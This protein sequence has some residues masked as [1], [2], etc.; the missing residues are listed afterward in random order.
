MLLGA[1]VVLS[2]SDLPVA[3]GRGEGDAG[4]SRSE[5]IEAPTIVGVKTSE[6]E[7]HLSWTWTD[8]GSWDIVSFRVLS[9][10]WDPETGRFASEKVVS[11]EGLENAASYPAGGLVRGSFS[12][13]VPAVGLYAFRVE[14][15]AKDRAVTRAGSGTG[16]DAAWRAWR[17]EK[18]L[19]GA[20]GWSVVPLPG[21]SRD[22]LHDARDTRFRFFF[23]L[24]R[25]P[26]LVRDCDLDYAVG[27]PAALHSHDCDW[28][29]GERALVLAN[30]D[31]GTPGAW[32]LTFA[33]DE[34]GPLFGDLYVESELRDDGVPGE[35]VGRRV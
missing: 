14:V 15:L 7:V 22:L 32:R 24:Y 23:E 11:E 21:T 6:L 31:P 9:S 17:H 33:W 10:R 13:V 4:A 5:P 12:Y 18:I 20:D 2:Q 35:L 19:V 27:W 25:G 8:A 30:P 29:T 26:R 34:D 16:H 1:V 28:E 3:T